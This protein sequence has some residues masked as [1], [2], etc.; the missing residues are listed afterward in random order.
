MR[1]GGRRTLLSACLSLWLIVGVATA[2]IGAAPP[3]PATN[4]KPAAGGPTISLVASDV[5]T[6]GGLAPAPDGSL[7]A[8]DWSSNRVWHVDALGAKTNVA[9]TG[10]ADDGN[11]HDGAD[12]LSVGLTPLEIDVDA[13]GVVYIA[14]WKF[15]Y[16]LPADGL[17]HRVFT[18]ETTQFGDPISGLAVDGDT[19][20]VAV[21]A[22]SF[23]IPSHGCS[24]A[25]RIEAVARYGLPPSS[26][27]VAS[28]PDLS[29]PRRMTVGPNSRRYVVDGTIKDFT[30]LPPASFDFAPMAS[31]GIADIEVDQ[32]G[33]V[34]A[35][36]WDRAALV[37]IEA[38]GSPA[39]IAGTLD[40]P[41]STGD[42]GE[43]TAALLDHP[44]HLAT[45]PDGTIY[46]GMGTAIRRI[47]PAPAGAATP[48]PPVTL[49]A[50][51]RPALKGAFDVNW[52]AP[53][54][55]GG[56]P[57]T[58]Y[59]VS[60]TP[61]GPDYTV[62]STTRYALVASLNAGTSYQISIR[63]V[64]AAGEGPPK[65]VN[66]TARS[67]AMF[68]PM[69]PV[70]VLDSRTT[71]GGWSGAL[72]SGA[73]GVR[74]L[75]LPT[76]AYSYAAAVLN[77]TVTDGTANSF[78]SVFPTG[79]SPPTAS[80]LNFAKGQTIANHVTTKVTGGK[81]SFFNA[82]GNVHVIADLVGYY[83]Y[84]QASAGFVPMVPQRVLD[85]RSAVG[86]WGGKV[87]AFSTKPLAFA[88]LPA[89]ATNVVLNVTA[90]DSTANSYLKIAPMALTA[91]PNVSS[92]NFGAGETVANL[93]TVR[94]G[95]NRS[96]RIGTANGSTHVVADLVGYYDTADPAGEWFHPMDPVRALDSRGPVGG[97]K[98]MLLAGDAN[99][100][101][102]TLGGAVGVPSTAVAVVLN[103]TVTNGTLGSFLTVYPA[104]GAVPTASN[105]NFAPG[106][107][108]PNQVIVKLGT[109]G[110]ASFF[111]EAGA[112]DVIADVGGYFGRT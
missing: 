23:C 20:L 76:V 74:S 45:T 107:T 89:T 40:T 44:G 4:A 36:L 18:N 11:D 88:S 92:L 53:W 46:V 22:P 17:L 16:A 32:A 64:N 71:T 95:T 106:E 101:S 26:T 28:P 100:R 9:G 58:G 69:D 35:A 7:Y 31:G 99:V 51:A 57:I 85:S 109:G 93:V 59:H 91:M 41:G 94:L 1:R 77:V 73:P 19:V 104:G 84:A 27:Y 70:R 12:A 79:T 6:G 63:A 33:R 66:A 75:T 102:L 56:S 3:I 5:G 37:R 8:G 50:T 39:V 15:V 25:S 98:G 43:A 80:N 13:F 29:T 82:A 21:N 67:G 78:V 81:I 103:A 110:A 112:T 55:E 52:S 105:V 61:G 48:S 96:I 72:G 2:S 83:T 38:D 65:V 34:I 90:T 62:G 108:R 97:W 87:T 60:V 42:G 47:T 68:V 10:A 49:T 30:T 86:G 14:T 111:N 54:Y 24:N